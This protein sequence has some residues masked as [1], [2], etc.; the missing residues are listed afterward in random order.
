M[1]QARQQALEIAGKSYA[2]RFIM[3]CGNYKDFEE[4][5]ATFS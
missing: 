3:G 1:K 4:N 5:D 2:S